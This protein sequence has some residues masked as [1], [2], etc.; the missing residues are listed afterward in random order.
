MDM[1][2]CRKVHGSW[3]HN[4]ESQQK[5]LISYREEQKPTKYKV[6]F[7]GRDMS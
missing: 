2:F 1:R 4:M 5:S 7:E 6:I 3:L